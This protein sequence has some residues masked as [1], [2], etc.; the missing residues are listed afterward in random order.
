M[1][2]Y[3][4]NPHQAVSSV[5]FTTVM[6]VFC[7]TLFNGKRPPNVNRKMTNPA[8]TYAGEISLLF[9]ELMTNDVLFADIMCRRVACEII[10]NDTPLLNAAPAQSIDPALR[11]QLPE[12]AKLVG[13]LNDC[14]HVYS[15]RQALLASPEL[16]R[17]TETTATISK[18]LDMIGGTYP[19][20]QPVVVLLRTSFNALSKKMTTG[21]FDLFVRGLGVV[22]VS[23]LRQ[24]SDVVPPVMKHIA[25]PDDL[26]PFLRHLLDAASE[27]PAIDELLNESMAKRLVTP[28]PAPQLHPNVRDLALS[29]PS[30]TRQPTHT[31]ESS[32][33]AQVAKPVRQVRFAEPP[34]AQ[35]TETRIE[36]DLVIP[37]QSSQPPDVDPVPRTDLALPPTSQQPPASNT[38]CA[39][40]PMRTYY[41][42]ARAG[43]FLPTVVRGFYNE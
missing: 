41:L 8:A 3:A 22:A 30:N 24:V 15:T 18:I 28:S 12:A 5:R 38:Q 10:A 26:R 31:S 43:R 40:P 36:A 23:I 34:P 13:L 14:I 37:L 6:N 7:D 25:C 33:Q 29:A 32:P 27:I 39:P 42:S 16:I 21:N 20:V 2:V 4:T 1:Y 11:A 9:L 35:P 17:H 19:A